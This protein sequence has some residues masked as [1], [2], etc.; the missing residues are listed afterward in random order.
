MAKVATTGLTISNVPYGEAVKTGELV[1]WSNGKLVR[2][3]GSGSTPIPAVGIA[4]ASYRDGE[5][6]AMHLAG[7]IGGFANLAVGDTQYLSLSI[8]GDIQSAP[9]SGAGNLMQAVG[10]AV[11]P[12]RLVI[13]I[14]DGGSYL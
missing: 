11:A 3:C 12:N 8:A 10:Y 7:E 6:G 9:P 4:A 5:F 2:A 14:R 13:A 1:G